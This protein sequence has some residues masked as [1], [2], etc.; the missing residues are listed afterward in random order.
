MVAARRRA[1]LEGSIDAPLPAPDD[2]P[3]LNYKEIQKLMKVFKVHRGALDFD[4]GFIL[5]SMVEIN[6]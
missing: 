4:K 6:D 1:A 3:T 5:K 2:L